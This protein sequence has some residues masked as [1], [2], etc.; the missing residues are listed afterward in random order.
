[1]GFILQN[2]RIAITQSLQKF[3]IAFQQ[4]QSQADKIVKVHRAAIGEGALIVRVNAPA[5]FSE[6]QRRR[7]L[8]KF[9]TQAFGSQEAIFG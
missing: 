9:G 8:I 1:M 2:K 4:G 5:E 6:R 3:F 7:R